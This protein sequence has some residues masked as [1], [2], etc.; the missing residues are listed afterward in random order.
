MAIAAP[1][2]AARAD[3]AATRPA[4]RSTQRSAVRTTARSTVRPTRRPAA[5]RDGL[6][7]TRRGKLVLGVLSTLFLLVVVLLSGRVTAEAGT[8]AADQGAATGVVVVQGGENLWQ[9]AKAVAP[10]V[11]PR[12]TVTLIRDLNG[13][14]DEPIVPGQ[15][16]VVPVAPAA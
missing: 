15:S 2:P 9:I 13:L 12:E 3:R 5:R 4:T 6:V 10:S 8:S 1:F 14:G 11:D 7:L 16:L